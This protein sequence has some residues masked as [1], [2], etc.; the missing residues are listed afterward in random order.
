MRKLFEFN[1]L[2]RLAGYIAHKTAHSVVCNHHTVRFLGVQPTYWGGHFRL[3]NCRDCKSTISE[4]TIR[5]MQ[6][7]LKHTGVI[8]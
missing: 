4:Q 8:K 2:E 1:P 6:T 3:Y 7:F 5:E